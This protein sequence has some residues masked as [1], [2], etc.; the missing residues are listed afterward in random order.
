[1]AKRRAARSFSRKPRIRTRQRL[2]L[3]ADRS[4]RVELPDRFAYPADESA[5]FTADM[6]VARTADFKSTPHH[7]ARP[8]V[9]GRCESGNL[10]HRIQRRSAAAVRVPAKQLG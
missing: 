5:R 3:Y 8:K 6:A 4:R 1:M 9:C 7:Q 10:L 2:S